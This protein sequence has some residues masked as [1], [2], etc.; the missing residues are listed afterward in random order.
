MARQQTWV[1][2]KTPKTA[3]SSRLGIGLG[4]FLERRYGFELDAH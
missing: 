2:V 4:A 1:G 3:V